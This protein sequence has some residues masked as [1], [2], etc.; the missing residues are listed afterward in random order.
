MQLIV[1]NSNV[2]ISKNKGLVI[3][4]IIYQFV[5]FFFLFWFNGIWTFGDYLIPNSGYS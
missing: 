1:P 5:Y 2:Q 4:I 3:S